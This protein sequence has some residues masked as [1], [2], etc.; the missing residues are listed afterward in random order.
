LRGVANTPTMR[1]RSSARAIMDP[2]LD[3]ELDVFVKGQRQPV[4][5]PSEP[6]RSQAKHLAVSKARLAK[7]TRAS[8]P[9]KQS[10][11]PTGCG[12]HAPHALDRVWRWEATAQPD[13]LT[14]FLHNGLA[15]PKIKMTTAGR[16]VSSGQ[17]ARCFRLGV[18][19]CFCPEGALVY[20]GDGAAGGARGDVIGTVAVR[21]LREFV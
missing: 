5:C 21:V 14:S 7:H 3:A 1:Q 19:R 8:W 16:R 13:L 2:W 11:N 12:T 17:R 15:A 20:A 4:T 18:L 9:P 6:K 10:Q